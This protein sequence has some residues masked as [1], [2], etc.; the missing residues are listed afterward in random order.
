MSLSPETINLIKADWAAVPYGGKRS[1]IEKWAKSLGCS[2]GAIYGKLA[3]G[4]HRQRGQRKLDNIEKVAEVVGP[5]EFPDPNLQAIAAAIFK[6]AGD[7]EQPQLTDLLSAQMDL[8][9]VDLITSL[10]E[11]GSRKANFQSNLS[12]ALDYIRDY[13]HQQQLLRTAESL[14]RGESDLSDEQV[15]KLLHEVQSQ[16]R[17]QDQRNPGIRV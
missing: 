17:A 9:Q 14:R 8:D 12:G 6:W 7:T 10:A 16:L 13:R 1:I 2:C 11:E 5:D 4:R 15:N 3:V